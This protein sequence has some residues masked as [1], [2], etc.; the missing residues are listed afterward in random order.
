MT[1]ALIQPVDDPQ[2]GGS[3][4]LERTLKA[5]LYTVFQH[6]LERKATGHAVPADPL[7]LGEQA[8]A[9]KSAL[10]KSAREL[11]Q[12]L[13]PAGIKPQSHFEKFLSALLNGRT[14]DSV[15]AHKASLEECVLKNSKQLVTP[16]LEERYLELRRACRNAKALLP[17]LDLARAW[18]P[19]LE[20]GALLSEAFQTWR[21]EKGMAL[22][23]ELPSRVARTLRDSGGVPEAFCRLGAGLHHLLI[24]E[25]QD[26]SA[27][28]WDVLF[29]IA[30]ECLSKHG[31]LVY[32]GDVKQAV[33]SWRG[34]EPALFLRAALQ[35]ERSRVDTV[36]RES[37]PDNWRSAPAIV[38]FNNAAF[39]SLTDK[40]HLTLAARALMPKDAPEAMLEFLQEELGHAFADVRQN[41]GGSESQKN[42]PEGFVSVQRLTPGDDFKESVRKAFTDL[43]DQNLLKRRKPQDIAVLT[44]TNNEA[45]VV[46]KWLTDMNQPVLTEN[47]LSLAEHPVVRGA[48]AFLSFLDYPP[49]DMAFWEFISCADLFLGPQRMD[50]EDLVDWLLAAE[51]GEPLYRRFRRDYPEVW[52]RF[53]E[54]FLKGA[55]PAG[56]YD[57]ILELFCVCRVFDRPVSERDDAFLRPF[58]ELIH[59]AETAGQI[60]LSAFL[61]FWRNKGREGKIPQPD[62]AQAVRVL[63]VHKAKGLQFPVVVVPFQTSPKKRGTTLITLPDPEGLLPSPVTLPEGET[64]T[65]PLAKALGNAYFQQTAKE[66]Q[67]ELNLLYVAWTR[68]EEELYLM[69]PEPGSP[70]EPPIAA[71]AA[72]LLQ[73]AG[74]DADAPSA[75]FGEPP[76][77]PE[78]PAGDD[79]GEPA[80]P[81]ASEEASAESPELGSPDEKIAATLPK[82]VRSPDA[83]PLPA[84]GAKPPL[85][86][87]PGLKILRPE[88]ADPSNRAH[89]DE[90][91][92]GIVAHRALQLFIPGDDSLGAVKRAMALCNVRDDDAMAHGLAAGLQ[93]LAG[94][95][96][97]SLCHSLG[98]REMDLIDQDGRVHRPDLLAFTPDETIVVDYK[99]GQEEP[100]HHEQVRR[101]L[102]LAN[103]LPPGKGR[104]LRGLI[105]YLDLHRVRDVRADEG[106]ATQDP[107]PTDKGVAARGVHPKAPGGTP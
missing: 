35:I 77:F 28:Q 20:F 71:A 19:F 10:L 105:A 21:R 8:A 32:V 18:H 41:V 65:L 48:I 31:S 58:L 51:P 50:Y 56:P 49:D 17:V 95:D 91:T 73:A 7:L 57:L 87:L 106:A 33:Y 2:K 67:E 12:A 85:D 6:Q 15:F 100:A 68:P 37:L 53:F 70:K 44:R 54:P 30:L 60:S 98:L 5:R 62:K 47:S 83:Q 104:T 69:L 13:A 92:R 99:T 26:T 23:R 79:S 45:G 82:P 46:A 36:E 74:M 27:S 88:L 59:R 86:W 24:D 96:F 84:L 66:R 89:E 14:P 64:L 103:A 52:Q 22:L 38:A 90:R 29:E 4:W 75:T 43:F 102:R 94:Q 39:G 34:G 80:K 16:A 25:F 97:F 107:R 11:S 72:V 81:N 9:Q 78:P 55:D 3:F 40:A 101:Y 42:G 93:W 76:A 61:E 63:T 1:D